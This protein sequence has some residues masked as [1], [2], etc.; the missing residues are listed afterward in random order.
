VSTYW[1]NTSGEPI[2]Y[3]DVTFVPVNG[4]G[5]VVS[6]EV[7]G[8]RAFTGRA[9]GPFPPGDDLVSARWDAAW[10]NGAI[11]RARITR[12]RVEYGTDRRTG[13]V[14]I[15]DPARLAALVAPREACPH[16][17]YKLDLIRAEAAGREYPWGDNWGN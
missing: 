1:A 4:V 11:E 12:V 17:E 8:H 6:D 2:R 3:L 13:S 15:T 7:D 9:T 5:D 16:V 10:F 14:T